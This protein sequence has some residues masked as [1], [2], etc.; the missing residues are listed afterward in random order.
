MKKLML[1]VV[2]G[3]ASFGAVAQENV[4][5]EMISTTCED[6]GI[7]DSKGMLYCKEK[8]AELMVFA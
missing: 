7:N 2:L 4:V 3:L 1:G 6:I 8:S 5:E